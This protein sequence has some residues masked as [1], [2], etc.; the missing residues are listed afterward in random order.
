MYICMYTVGVYEIY[1]DPVARQKHKQK[2]VE[3]KK[4]KYVSVHIDKYG[5]YI[6]INIL[7]S[8]WRDSSR[9]SLPPENDFAPWK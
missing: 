7:Y 4:G 8:E 1:K 6:M 3:A 9:C 2:L 5:M